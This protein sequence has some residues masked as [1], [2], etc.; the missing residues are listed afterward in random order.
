MKFFPFSFFI[1]GYQ[2]QTV[3]YPSQNIYLKSCSSRHSNQDCH[4]PTDQRKKNRKTGNWTVRIYYY[5]IASDLKLSPIKLYAF[6][7]KRQCIEA[8][9]REMNCHYYLERLPFRNI[10]AN[11]FWIACKILTMT[12]FKMFQKKTLPKSLQHLLLKT[13][14][15]KILQKGLKATDAGKVEVRS[16]DKNTWLLRRL[17]AKTERMKIAL[18]AHLST[19]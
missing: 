19:G 14:L 17:I 13:F 11:E 3:E 7:H 15:R 12:M 16:K 10:K 9:F 18:N 8:G 2:S 1:T 5:G 6:Y 4:C